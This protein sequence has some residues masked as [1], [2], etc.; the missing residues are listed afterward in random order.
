MNETQQSILSSQVS[1]SID[2][3]QE[4]YAGALNAYDTALELGL[5]TTQASEVRDAV[6]SELDKH[7][8][9]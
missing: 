6:F 4:A 7:Y 2:D 9:A 5:T 3:D 8:S 1:Y